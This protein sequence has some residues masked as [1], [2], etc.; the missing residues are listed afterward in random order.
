ML[1]VIKVYGLIIISIL[2]IALAINFNCTITAEDNL[3]QT[4]K[5]SD[6][7]L[8]Q[9]SINYGELFIND[10]LTIDEEYLKQNYLSIVQANRNPLLPMEVVIKSYSL[11]PPSITLHGQL[12]QSLLLSNLIVNEQYEFTVLLERY[13]KEKNK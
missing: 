9:D 1:G 2:I 8:I 11:S 3:H 6:I 10:H 4:I 12:K 13:F 5:Q 7:V